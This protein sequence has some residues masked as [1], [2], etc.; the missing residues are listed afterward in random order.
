MPLNL[1]KIPG[2]ADI[3]TAVTELDGRITQLDGRIT[4]LEAYV[5]RNDTR[6]TNLEQAWAAIAAER[7]ARIEELERQVAAHEAG[8]IERQR[9]VDQIKR[10]TGRLRWA[11][12]TGRRT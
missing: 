7:T 6:I 10:D 1:P 2:I 11:A 12:R 4:Q 9:E 5:T 3:I 8:A